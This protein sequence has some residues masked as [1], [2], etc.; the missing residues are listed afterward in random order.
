[1]KPYALEDFKTD[2]DYLA[3]QQLDPEQAENFILSLLKKKSEFEL[4]SIPHCTHCGEIVLEDE[5]VN[6]THSCGGEWA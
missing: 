4:D 3:G 2:V 6:T 5:C 1:M